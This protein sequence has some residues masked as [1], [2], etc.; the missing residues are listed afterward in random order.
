[1]P[2]SAV[3][4]NI[5]SP[6]GTIP[7][8]CRASNA[9]L[10]LHKSVKSLRDIVFF[11]WLSFF[12]TRSVTSSSSPWSMSRKRSGVG[13]AAASA[14]VPSPLHSASP[15]IP[16]HTLRLVIL[17]I[18][19]SPQY[20]FALENPVLS[21]MASVTTWLSTA[22]VTGFESVPEHR[23]SPLSARA[24]LNLI[25]CAHAN[26]CCLIHPCPRRR[27]NLRH[28]HRAVC[29]EHTASATSPSIFRLRSFFCVNRFRLLLS[30]TGFVS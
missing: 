29:L 19:N 5:C 28:L 16:C 22:L 20:I 2:K 1:L 13:L 6:A 15:Q 3:P 14:T 4:I 17:L 21:K 9:G 26:A 24:G 12:T 25:C 8:P 11:I 30:S 18:K 23:R 27:D 7:A 10:G